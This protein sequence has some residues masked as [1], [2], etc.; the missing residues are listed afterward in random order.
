[1]KYRIQIIED[2]QDL[3]EGIRIFLAHQG[4][5]TCQSFC[6]MEA[7]RDFEAFKPHILLLDTLLPDA[8]GTELCQVFRKNKSVGIIFLTALSSKKN[9]VEG[10]N[11]GADDY[12][13]KPFDLDILLARIEALLKRLSIEGCE[14]GKCDDLQ[15]NLYK[16][17]ISYNGKFVG[18][19]QTE[20]RILHY[21]KTNKDFQTAESIMEHIYE[22]ECTGTPSRTISVHIA[23]IR[24]KLTDK[25]VTGIEIA[26]K[27][28]LGYRMSDN[29]NG[30]VGSSR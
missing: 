15:F 1:M 5:D 20:F 13:S 25:G 3:S 27:Y 21:L 23:K 14:F 17:D 6:G 7:I 28:K 19:T 24:K 29:N 10:F 22:T 12:I 8:R 16:N 4:Y 11:C 2:E 9:I 26:S 18:L 30:T